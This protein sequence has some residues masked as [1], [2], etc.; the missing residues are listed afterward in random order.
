MEAVY[1]QQPMPTNLTGVPVSIDVFDSNGNYR[2]IGTITSDAS[3]MFAF[4]WK[5]DIPGQYTVIATFV[6]SQSYYPSSASTAFYASE[7]AATPSPTPIAEASMADQYILPGII[8]I[9]VTIVIVGVVLA[10]LMFRKKP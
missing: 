9:I 8:G 1:M 2:N 5:P 4:T 6:G 10:L 3:G 7:P